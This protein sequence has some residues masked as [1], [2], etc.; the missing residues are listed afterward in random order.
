MAVSRQFLESLRSGLN[1]PGTRR[2]ADDDLVGAPV[3]L[4]PDAKGQTPPP[5]GVKPRL[6]QHLDAQQRQ[7][8]A[9]VVGS[10]P[11][12]H[13]VQH[14][15]SDVDYGSTENN[16]GLLNEAIGAAHRWLTKP[17]FDETGGGLAAPRGAPKEEAEP[18]A[19]PPP[20]D[21]PTGV[22]P[23]ETAQPQAQGMG[24]GQYVEAHEVAQA[25]PERQAQLGQAF[26]DEEGAL[27]R[28]GDIAAHGE[29]VSGAGQ[30][31]AG[32]QEL[33]DLDQ[34]AAN[35]RARQEYLDK[36]GADIEKDSAA[37]A[38]QSVDPERFWKTRSTPQKILGVIALALGGFGA[39]SRGTRNGAADMIA[40][41]INQDI[42]AQRSDIENKW[43][44]IRGR[45]SILADKAAQYG[46]LDVAERQQVA[47]RLHGAL[48]MV[49]GAVARATSPIE[50]AQAQALAAE[51]EQKS[52]EAGIQLNKWVSAY[53]GSGVPAQ[54][55]TKDIKAS[56]L[57]RMG[58]QWVDVGDETT[59]RQYNIQNQ[60]RENVSSTAGQLLELLRDPMSAVPGSPSRGQLLALGKSLSIEDIKS[61]GSGTRSGKGMIEFLN[62]ALGNYMAHNPIERAQAREAIQK[63]LQKSEADGV[64]T[65]QH[66][67]GNWVVERATDP[68]HPNSMKIV[69]KFD[70][71]SLDNSQKPANGKPKTLKLLG[72]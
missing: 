64:E 16:P 49:Q 61:M 37:M 45:H 46:N 2:S 36:I 60:A 70:P 24:G 63:F 7:K 40:D 51:L 68:T 26:E 44:S 33:A 10:T 50:R 21:E 54:G 48:L 28:K 18:A 27:L 66:L 17:E 12:T 71:S 3:V 69:G 31:N 6:W 43:N 9:Q 29:D 65:A 38:N 1:A 72:Q 67:S 13:T 5:A 41:S 35:Q 8:V 19:P 23:H 39:A 11:A 25:D 15:P 53:S 52:V 42:A 55:L 4:R 58:D 56:T 14:P 59:A 32:Q 30:E 47:S 22:P 20:P 62:K 34:V 57:V